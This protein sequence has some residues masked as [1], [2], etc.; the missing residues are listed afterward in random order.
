LKKRTKK[1]LSI[2]VVALPRRGH[3]I[4]EVFASLSKRSAF[5][6]LT[7]HHEIGFACLLWRLRGDAWRRSCRAGRRC[8]SGGLLRFRMMP[9]MGMGRM[10]GGSC[11]ITNT[12]N[13]TH[14]WSPVY[15]QKTID[16][17]CLGK[18]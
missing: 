4:A 8:L 7:L 10:R 13:G 11:G 12:G 5:V 1:L 17:Q 2:S 3:R 16:E 18:P 9:M 6:Q 14:R 15:T